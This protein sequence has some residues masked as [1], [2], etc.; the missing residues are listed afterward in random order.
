MA[1]TAAQE[2]LV[3]KLINVVQATIDDGADCGDVLGAIISTLCWAIA[4]IPAEHH[5]AIGAQLA[6]TVP[7]IMKRAAYAGAQVG[8]APQ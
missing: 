2:E 5:A 3:T 4:S 1:I 7:V 6:K 8:N